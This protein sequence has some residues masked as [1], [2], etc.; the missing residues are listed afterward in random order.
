MIAT[1]TNKFWLAG[2]LL[3]AVVGAA[4]A[5]TE[6]G[7]IVYHVG[8][9][10]R[11]TFP[12]GTYA[13]QVNPNANRLTF[14]L[15]HT[16]VAA[17]TT[18]HFHRIG[19]YVLT[20]P[21]ATPTVGFST[22]NRIPEPFTGDDGLALLPGSG[23]FAGKLVSGLGPA[24]LPGDAIE[25]EYGLLPVAPMDEL[26]P[27]D[28]ALHPDQATF[29]GVLHP[30][31]YLLNTSGGVYK[32]P[33]ANTTVGLELTSMSPGLSIHNAAGGVLF[34]GGV[35]STETLGASANWLWEP[36]Y[37]VDASAAPGSQ[38][39]ATFILKDL[40]ASAR[41]GD[42]APF[43]FDFIVPTAQVPEPSSVAIAAV[44]AAVLGVLVCWKRR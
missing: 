38:F 25:E 1:T 20:G 11:Q 26:F 7:V 21:A 42:S 35:S 15:S 5:S 31:H 24:A 40:S 22:N 27:S 16:F 43:S 10:G 9:D 39:S 8:V 13:G 17:P 12:S 41:F 36:V 18:N 30:E 29:P 37:A 14:F 6:P 33:V 4:Q 44:G 28:N 34:A 23:P 32:T 19:S 3:T 2:L